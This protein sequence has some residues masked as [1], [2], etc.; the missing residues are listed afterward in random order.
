MSRP[1]YNTVPNTHKERKFYLSARLNT[2]ALVFLDLSHC[3]YVSS[4]KPESSAFMLCFVHV[5]DMSSVLYADRPDVK[6]VKIC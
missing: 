2:N 6:L 4:F 3:W 1:L 5:I